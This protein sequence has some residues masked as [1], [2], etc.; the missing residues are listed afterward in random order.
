MAN[1]PERLKE[2][3]KKNQLTQQKL[4]DELGV[5]RVNVTKWENGN[6]EPN[7]SQIADIAIYFNTSIDYLIGKIDKEYSDY[8]PQDFENK[9]HNELELLVQQAEENIF[10]SLAIAKK[11]GV[12]LME[13]KNILIELGFS[14]E[15]TNNLLKILY[16]KQ[17]LNT[18]SAPKETNDTNLD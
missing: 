7:L 2:L 5:N 11:K 1:F 3:R 12:P 4:A 15:K 10:K 17:N 14:D 16:E 6:I 9:S 8:I 13:M 18:N